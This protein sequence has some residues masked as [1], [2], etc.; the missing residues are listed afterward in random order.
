MVSIIEGLHCTAFVY[1]KFQFIVGKEGWKEYEGEG[2]QRQKRRKRKKGKGGG[3]TDE[4][5]R[6]NTNE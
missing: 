4:F 1:S 6:V 3:G 5:R 2:Q